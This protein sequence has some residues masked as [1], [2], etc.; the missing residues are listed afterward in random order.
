MFLRHKRKSTRTCCAHEVPSQTMFRHQADP[1]RGRRRGK[2]QPPPPAPASLLPPLLPVQK[3]SWKWK[4][5]KSAELKGFGE[6]EEELGE[7][8]K[9]EFCRREMR[10]GHGTRTAKRV[11]TSSSSVCP[12]KGEPRVP[13]PEAPRGLLRPP[14]AGCI[15]QTG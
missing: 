3:S 10:Q 1:T 12:R 6:K 2:I 9:E 14:L 5:M 13:A 11:C 8:E 7:E 15:S 4:A